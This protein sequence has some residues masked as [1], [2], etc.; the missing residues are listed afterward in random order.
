MI[1][2]SLKQ[3]KMTIVYNKL[4]SLSQ[5][6]ANL[7][8]LFV[9]NIYCTLSEDM[10]SR[11]WD[12]QFFRYIMYIGY[13][14]VIVTRKIFLFNIYKILCYIGLSILL[15]S[16]LC[17]L[18]IS[19]ELNACAQYQVYLHFLESSILIDFTLFENEPS[20]IIIIISAAR[21]EAKFHSVPG[22]EFAL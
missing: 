4:S 6:I 14:F 22:P 15:F 13:S 9:H 10:H 3:M 11:F 1:K 16:I 18:I 19:I 17:L 20:R 21:E 12:M 7:S 2:R 5:R 8:S